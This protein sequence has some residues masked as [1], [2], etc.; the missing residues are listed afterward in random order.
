[1]EMW[2]KWFK[3]TPAH[4]LKNA[5]VYY[6]TTGRIQG[7]RDRGGH[8]VLIM[9][10]VCRWLGVKDSK[11]ILSDVCDKTKWRIMIANTFRQCTI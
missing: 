5:T 9:D 4:P 2:T 1:M 3:K 6:V 10:G 7:K 8:R 11:D